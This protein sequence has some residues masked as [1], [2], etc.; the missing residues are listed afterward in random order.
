M[1]PAGLKAIADEVGRELVVVCGR[2][3]GD[4]FRRN[5][6]NL[7]LHVVECPEAVADAQ[8][9]DE[10]T[11]DPATRALENETQ[12]R[13]TSR[14]RWRQGR[15]DPAKR[16]HHSPSA[17]ESCAPSIALRRAS[18]G[19]TPT[20]RGP[21]RRRSR[22]SGR[23]GS[24]GR[25]T[26]SRAPR[27]ASTPICCRPPTARHRS[28]STRSTRSQAAI[29]S[30]RD[31]PPSPT[32]TSSSPAATPTSGS[33]RSARRSRC[34]TA[35]E[36]VLRD[37]WRRHLPFLF[38]RAGSGV[39]GSA[40]SGRR[41]AQPRVRGVR[42]ARN[43]RRIHDAGLRVGHRLHLFHA[44][45]STPRRLQRQAP[46]VGERQGH[47]PRAAAPVGNRA[48]EGMGVEFVDA[49]R[50]AAAGLSQHDR[51]H[52]GGGRGP[53]RHLRPR[54]DHRGLVSSPWRRPTAVSDDSARVADARYERHDDLRLDDVRPMVAQPLQPGQRRAGRGDRARAC[55]LRQGPDRL[56][57]QRQLRRSAAGRARA[58]GG[59]R[60][61]RRTG[62]DAARWSSRAPG[63]VAHQIERPD[64]RLGGT[65][66][67]DVF[68]R[69]GGEI[70][71]SW[72]G[73]CFG[74]G[75]MPSPAANVP[76]RRSIATGTTA[77]ASAA[78][79]ISPAR[80]SSPPRRS[81]AT[82]RPPT[83]SD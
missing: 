79:A 11:F 55:D 48:G 26:S 7:G 65:S 32:I 17:G 44:R 42:R 10:L 43:R 54:R 73:P 24:I 46:A 20:T 15:R 5:A 28:R 18:S 36:A 39:P 25:A 83:S 8:D 67:A 58:R 21:C 50:A 45:T 13:R 80:R 60:T 47:R 27:C 53:E 40:H 81:W 77:W 41:L 75:P 63:G 12:G 22:S 29:R 57:H 1:S 30:R 71:Q 34:G 76:S 37:A 72:C 2:Q 4:I 33:V 49:R 64:A 82:W 62:R 51:Q 66:I 70:R 59:A 16:R 6:F 69:A 52:D 38:P 14:C 9:G 31:R 74:Q 19:R 23:I 61:R 56:V 3:M 35:R 68:R 78:R